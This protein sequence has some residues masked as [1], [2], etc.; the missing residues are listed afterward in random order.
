MAAVR[1]G[2]LVVTGSA[3]LGGQAGSDHCEELIHT[4]LALVSWTSLIS[5]EVARQR[6]VGGDLQAV[7]RQLDAIQVNQCLL[8]YFPRRFFASELQRFS[9]VHVM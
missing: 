3:Q 9:I 8:T 6:P 1:Y 2:R 7:R 4:M 5:D